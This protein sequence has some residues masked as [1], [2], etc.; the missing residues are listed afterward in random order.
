MKPARLLPWAASLLVHAGILVALTGWL[1]AAGP[2]SA[3]LPTVDIALAA[4][5][6]APGPR[7][8]E[9]ATAKS[10]TAAAPRGVP[11]AVT[12]RGAG[13]VA[14]VEGAVNQPLP[15][16]AIDPAVEAS[17]SGLLQDPLEAGFA[18]TGPAAAAANPAEGTPQIGWEGKARV[19]LKKRNPQF[20]SALRAS[21]QEVE[22]EARITVAPSGAVLRVEI[23]RS[24][25]YI[26]I[27]ASVE[28]ALRDFLF[29]PVNGRGNAL[30]TVKFRFRLEK[31]D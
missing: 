19:L 24:T 20:P 14:P 18:A 27:D 5:R 23:T 1:V 21:G 3:V 26:E 13:G 31:T 30:G 25:G 17:P 28:A 11:G 29:S 7:A 2:G 16:P 22:G 12:P 9:A 4:P 8:Q 6:G 15:I 10:E